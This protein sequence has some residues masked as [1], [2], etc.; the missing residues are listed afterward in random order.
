MTKNKGLCPARRT[1]RVQQGSRGQSST[2][3][4]EMLDQTRHEGDVR[5]HRFSWLMCGGHCVRVPPRP[6]P[7]LHPSILLPEGSVRTQHP[8]LILSIQDFTSRLKP[9]R[10]KR[11][12]RRKKRRRGNGR[13]GGG[14]GGGRGGAW[15]VWRLATWPPLAA[16][17]CWNSSSLSGGCVCCFQCWYYHY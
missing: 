7:S 5:P 10:R 15:S 12:R 4:G 1:G 9:S 11:R 14:R 16:L 3:Q 2:K 8:Q 17:H 6:P 13:E